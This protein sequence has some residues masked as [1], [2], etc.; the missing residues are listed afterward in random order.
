[1]LTF[2]YDS[3]DMDIESL[4][5]KCNLLGLDCSLLLFKPTTVSTEIFHIATLALCLSIIAGNNNPF[6]TLKCTRKF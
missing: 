5:V 2:C 4:S 6:S 3:I 1:M